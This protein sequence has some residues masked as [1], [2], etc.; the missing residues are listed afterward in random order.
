MS[1]FKN[2][3][4]KYKNKYLQLKKIQE[5]GRV[6]CHKAYNNIR[7]TCWAVAIQTIFTFGKA[8]SKQLEDVM[9]SFKPSYITW[10]NPFQNISDSKK[11]FITKQINK[12][13][14]NTELNNIFTK[15]IYNERLS[16]ILD[17]F[18]DRYYSKILEFKY[19][20]KPISTIDEENLLR[21][22]FVIADNFKKLFNYTIFSSYR[23]SDENYGGNIIAQY[24][25]TNLLS[26]F[27][28]D[29]KVSLKNYYD[30]FNLIDFNDKTDIGIL[31]TID[32][33][34]CCLYICNGEEKYYNDNDRTVYDCEWK[35]LLKQSNE[36]NLYIERGEVIRRIDYDSYQKKENLQKV[37]YL[38]VVSK[39]KED[40]ALDKEI[41]NILKFP[42]HDTT[43]IQDREILCILAY[44]YYYG[45]GVAQDDAEAARLYRLAAAQGH[46][47]AQYC[48]GAMLE[49]GR[50]IAQDYAEAARL[51]RLSVA[52]GDAQAQ[53]NLGLM[54]L[55]GRGVAQDN[56]E[57]V[58]LFRLAAAQ[59]LKYDQYNLGKMYHNGRG[60]A[61]DYAEAVRL[62]RLAAAQGH[63]EAQY[64]LGYMFHNG[65]GVAQDQAEAVRWYRLA[66]EQGNISAQMLLGNMFHNGK[67]VAQ[68]QAEAVRWYRFAAEQGDISAQMLL[69]DMFH[70]GE[71]VAQD[72]AEAVLWY[73]LAAAQG[74]DNAQFNLGSM[75]K[76][77][78]GVA[79]D[80]AEAVR[81]YSL[82]AEQGNDDAQLNLGSMYKNGQGV[83]Q[84]FKEAQLLTRRAALLGNANAQNNLGNMFEHGHGIKQDFSEAMRWYRLAAAQGHKNAQIRLA[85]AILQPRSNRV[86][87]K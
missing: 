44:H 33:H 58:R 50:G 19:T 23:K 37:L 31:I 8:T 48:L 43:N 35:D 39:Q 27:F 72:Q 68:D 64:T 32:D 70:N 79:Q 77:G 30:N 26:I 40:S 29:Y 7:G 73:R 45:E 62:Y 67:G 20:Q 57:A 2:K 81:W 56:A 17:K 87:N 24:L 12:V 5:G 80:Y 41:K 76:N 69:G 75:Y 38:T 6:D 82:A 14:E 4:L 60:V 65:E 13:K 18:I 3:Y 66:A 49:E 63:A 15:D 61:Q 78:Q 16:N 85:K 46:A 1:N 11:K 53:V 28:L 71:G 22:E 25:F 47:F 52:Q 36:N 55:N 34:T 42:N 21:C 59:G 51:Y 9:N 83:A 84:D 54:F 86:T 74:D 10:Y